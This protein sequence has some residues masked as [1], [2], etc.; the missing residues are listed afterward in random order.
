M[1]PYAYEGHL[2]ITDEIERRVAQEQI[3]DLPLSV[4]IMIGVQLSVAAF[5]IVAAMTIN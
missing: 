1:K 5:L 2:R 3:D 4:A